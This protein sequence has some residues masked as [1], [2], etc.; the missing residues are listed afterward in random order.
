MW[1]G[2]VDVYLFDP[3]R[4]GGSFA[5][6]GSRSVGVGGWCAAVG[7]VWYVYALVEPCALGVTYGCGPLALLRSGESGCTFESYAP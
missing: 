7:G 5:F 1:R 4:V 3:S 2:V 6:V